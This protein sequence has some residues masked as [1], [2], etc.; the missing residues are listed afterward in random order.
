MSGCA[1][2]EGAG[3]AARASR[4]AIDRMLS[5][6]AAE[7]TWIVAPAERAAEASGGTPPGNLRLIARSREGGDPARPASVCLASGL[8]R[9]LAGEGLVERRPGAVLAVSE[10]GRSRLRRLSAVAQAGAD[11]AGEEFLRQHRVSGK[12]RLPDG[13]GGIETVAVNL[14]ESP[15]AWLHAR[16]GRDGRPLVDAAQFEAGE[17]LRIDHAFGRIVP[18]MRGMAWAAFGSGA[19]TRGAGNPRGGI[20][21]ISDA[22]LAARTRLD[23]A[24]AAVGPELAGILV[25]V[26]CDLKGLADVE[27]S[28]G[29]PPRSAKVILSLALTRLARHYGTG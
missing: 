13:R 14:A 11:P 21:E 1:G 6:L 25:D 12:R 16:K 15:L 26:C 24:L 4:R 9:R 29:W 22:T 7:P 27:R 2:E 3:T 18:G 10:A 5:R 19:G 23:R 17:R 8:L 20:A 28:R